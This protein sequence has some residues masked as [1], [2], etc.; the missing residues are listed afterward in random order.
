M[1]TALLRRDSSKQGLQKLLR[2]TAQ[3]SLEDAEEVEREQRR[4][5][6]ESHSHPEDPHHVRI[7]HLVVS[8]GLHPQRDGNPSGSVIRE[9]RALIHHHTQP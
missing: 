4:R 5:R 6:R 3:R 7:H 1:S 8:C 9:L 2:V